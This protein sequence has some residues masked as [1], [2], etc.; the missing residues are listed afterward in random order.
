MSNNQPHGVPPTDEHGED[1]DASNQGDQGE[2]PGTRR[3]MFGPR[4]TRG[5]AEQR[6]DR[7]GRGTQRGA[8]GSMFGPTDQRENGRG[9]QGGTGG[10]RG[11]PGTMFGPTGHREVGQGPD[12]G[13]SGG[14]GQRGTS[15]TMFGRRRSQGEAGQREDRGGRG[16][17]R[18]AA[19]TMFGPLDSG[20]KRG[21]TVGN[22][23]GQPDGKRFRGQRAAAT[24][25]TKICPPDHLGPA[26]SDM[27]DLSLSASA[28]QRT[29]DGLVVPGS[30]VASEDQIK[31]EGGTTDSST[32]TAAKATDDHENGDHTFDSA[33]PSQAPETNEET[34]STAEEATTH[35]HD[36]DDEG[37]REAGN[38]AG[39]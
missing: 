39:I 11:T 21:T 3:T 33:C 26:G 35:G 5:E 28:A 17:Q 12:G 8:A 27:E 38:Q 6:E 18:G 19:G 4:R 34:A 36:D 14:A 31:T 24:A 1:N 2:E 10:E 15:Q 7:G 22:I 30:P 20:G 13:G 9:Q 37:L 25:E 16:A 29:S 32:T 23:F